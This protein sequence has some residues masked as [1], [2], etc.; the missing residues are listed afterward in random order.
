[1]FENIMFKIV[2]EF[3]FCYLLLQWGFEFLG[4]SL[5]LL[6][7]GSSIVKYTT[8]NSWKLP[9]DT[10]WSKSHMR[11]NF[12]R[13]L[14][15]SKLY[16]NCHTLY[17]YLQIELALTAASSKVKINYYKF[18]IDGLQQ[19]CRATYLVFLFV[20]LRILLFGVYLPRMIVAILQN[21]TIN[22]R[23]VPLKGIPHSVRVLEYFG[24]IL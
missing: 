3:F 8:N 9:N 18:I 10:S 17:Y 11:N 13:K 5:F 22:F 21:I 24:K 4:N 14:F 1:M 7:Q 12:N 20:T 19:W 16:R 23:Q 2:W 6:K 15:K